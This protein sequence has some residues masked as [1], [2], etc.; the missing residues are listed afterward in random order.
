M[1][2]AAT[3]FLL[4]VT[5]TAAGAVD[6]KDLAPCKPA[7]SRLCDRSAGYTMANLYRCGAT[8]AAQQT[9][10]GPRCREV[11]RRYGAL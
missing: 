1:R 4:V 10:V 3:A 2:I 8:L 11:L 5:A 7:A 9:R 6:M